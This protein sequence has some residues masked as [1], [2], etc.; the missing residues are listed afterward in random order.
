MVLFDDHASHERKLK[1]CCVVDYRNMFLISKQ[2][3]Y[4]GVFF[5]PVGSDD[6]VNAVFELARSISRLQL[7][8]EEMALFSAA[9]LF[10]PGLISSL[11]SISKI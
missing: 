1:S 2:C 6:L 11:I 5:H 10:S 7:T 4:F 3:F 8:E 9:V